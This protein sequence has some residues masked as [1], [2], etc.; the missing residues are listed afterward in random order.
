MNKHTIR[1]ILRRFFKPNGGSPSWLT[2]LASQRD[3]LWSLDF[4]R[5]ESIALKSY[6]VMLVIDQFSREIIGF[7]TLE[8]SVLGGDVC[9]CFNKLI[10]EIGTKPKY[11]STDNDPVFNFHLWQINLDM[12]KIG[13]IKSVPG[14]PTSHPF[15]ERCIGSTRRE[16]LDQILFWSQNDLDFKLKQFQKY[17]NEARPHYALGGLTPNG[18]RFEHG[19]CYEFKNYC[20]G[21]FSVPMAV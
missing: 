6:W 14:I 7:R 21:L 19:N 11:L 18:K 8:G 20:N 10:S 15:I 3:S 12:M 9:F 2:F 4:F 16:F 5:V 1:R 17:F 13:Q